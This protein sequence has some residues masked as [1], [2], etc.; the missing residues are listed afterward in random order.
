MCPLLLHALKFRIRRTRH[1]RLGESCGSVVRVSV[2]EHSGQGLCKSCWQ[3]EHGLFLEVSAP[4]RPGGARRC[5]QAGFH[6]LG[7]GLR[8]VRELDR[9]FANL[10]GRAGR[11]V[12]DEPLLKT[13]GALNQDTL[14]WN[15]SSPLPSLFFQLFSCSAVWHHFLALAGG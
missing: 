7:S 3:R 14:F 10:L 4:P 6:S 15:S 2:L 12:I 5:C 13:S 9:N 11:E 8:D 1:V